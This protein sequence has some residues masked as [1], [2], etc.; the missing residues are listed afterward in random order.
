MA[1]MISRAGKRRRVQ[2][3][4]SEEQ[5]LDNDDDPGATD[6]D[7]PPP[8][9]EL[10]SDDDPP[11]DSPRLQRPQ[12]RGF[13]PPIQQRPNSQTRKSAMS[14]LTFPPT[15]SPPPLPSQ[16]QYIS[17]RPSSPVSSLGL[18]SMIAIKDGGELQVTKECK[19]RSKRKRFMISRGILS[20]DEQ[21]QWRLLCEAVRMDYVQRGPDPPYESSTER[22]SHADDHES[23]AAITFR[24]R[25]M[26][27]P[28]APKLNDIQMTYVPSY[29]IV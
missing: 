1:A 4:E 27:G 8:D 26:F 25:D 10:P 2:S 23:S 19:E 7:D 16:S 18:D 28:D 22:S 24:H 9:D 17:G 15:S 11:Q 3:P 20:K 6:N 14:S 21:V 13:E 5:H 29:S 12:R